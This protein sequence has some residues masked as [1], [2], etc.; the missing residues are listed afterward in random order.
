TR[1][2]GNRSTPRWRVGLPPHDARTTPMDRTALITGITGQD[3]SYLAELLLDRG[4]RVCG[5]ARRTSAANSSRID[6][7]LDQLELYH[8][9]LPHH[10][11]RGEVLTRC[12]PDE[13]YNLAA[14]SFVA[15]SW[16]QPVLTA[17]VTGVGA[18]RLLEAV[19]QV[20]PNARF[21]QASSS[22]MFGQAATSPQDE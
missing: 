12:R 19:R 21:Y 11:P 16:A 8:R 10:S 14:Q 13:V 1:Q 18:T 22:E 9:D 17:E 2:R 3:G 4:Y 6:H 15:A 20:C 5:M 7:L